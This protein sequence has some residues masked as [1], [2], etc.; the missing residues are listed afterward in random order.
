MKLFYK[1]LCFIQIHFCI[2][3][4]QQTKNIY[5]DYQLDYHYLD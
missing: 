4:R 2:H 1:N 5:L 3:I